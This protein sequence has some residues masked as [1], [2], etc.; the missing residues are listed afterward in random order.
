M[1]GLPSA[2]LGDQR[3]LAR[4][5]EVSVS[6]PTQ[7]FSL[8]VNAAKGLSS[9]QLSR[10][11][12]VQVKLAFG[13][14]GRFVVHGRVAIPPLQSVRGGARIWEGPR[15]TRRSGRSSL[16]SR[17]CANDRAPCP[18]QPPRHCERRLLPGRS[19]QRLART[20]SLQ[21]VQAPVKAQVGGLRGTRQA[22]P[23]WPKPERP[24]IRRQALV[25]VVFRQG[26]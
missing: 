15:C 12:G 26:A 6:N 10:N 4:L 22:D 13:K 8:F 19:H 21:P 3:E 20:H 23:R 1:Q 14:V 25:R 17:L 24:P 16:S 7:A 11:L 18:T 9:L 5:P 2:I